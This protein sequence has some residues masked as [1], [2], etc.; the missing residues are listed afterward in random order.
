M[1]DLNSK[2]IPYNCAV[3]PRNVNK[4]QPITIIKNPKKKNADPI[5]FVFFVKNAKVFFNP[6]NDTMP[7]INEN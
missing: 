6:I 7:I 5:N 1:N 2:N 3:N 4:Y